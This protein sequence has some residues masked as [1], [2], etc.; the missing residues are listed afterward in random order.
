MLVGGVSQVFP[1]GANVFLRVFPCLLVVFPEVFPWGGGV[2][3]RCSHACWWCV[4]GV[5][6]GAEVFPG[7]VPM[8]ADGVPNG[9]LM[10]WRCSHEVFPCLL[11][12]CHRC[13]HGGR[14]VSGC[15]PMPVAGLPRGVPM[16]WRC[17][18]EVF[19]CL[20]RRMDSY[21]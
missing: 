17:F 13:S 16:G 4:T 12:V 20:M 15:V 6:M 19:P 2:P 10:R 8:L 21:S 1:W 18:H 3:T 14:G 11:V 9:V 5:P 7:G